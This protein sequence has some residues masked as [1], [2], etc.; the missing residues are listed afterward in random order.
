M[1]DADH[2]A[3]QMKSM[4]DAISARIRALSNLWCL[5]TSLTVMSRD[6][7]DSH[8]AGLGSRLR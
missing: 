6:I 8:D 1:D 2:R 4:L 3:E 5:G 7:A